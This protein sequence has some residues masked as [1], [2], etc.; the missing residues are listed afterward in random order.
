MTLSAVDGSVSGTSNPFDVN[1]LRTCPCSIW[2]I[3]ATPPI[4]N[5]SDGHPIE[6]GVRFRSEIDGYITGVRFYKGALNG[7]THVGHLW[8]GDGTQAGRSDVYGRIGR[9]LAAGA[10]RHTGARSPPAPPMWLR[11][12]RRLATLLILPNSSAPVS[13]ILHFRR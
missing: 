12:F 6:V 9:W 7:G 8:T 10:V 13:I 2:D 4:P 11:I 1:T 5:I 3:S